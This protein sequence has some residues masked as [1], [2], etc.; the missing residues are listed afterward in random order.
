MAWQSS[1]VMCLS[2]VSR[3]NLYI[4][5]PRRAGPM[6]CPHHLLGLAFAAV[7]NSPQRPVLAA[8]D[9]VAGVPEFR[10]NSAIGWILQHPNALASADLPSDLAPELK[11]V[12]LVVDRPALVGLHINCM[13]DAAEYLLERLFSREQ[14]HVRHSDQR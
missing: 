13:V 1:G 3:P 5:K 12:T 2:G 9:G 4:P 6:T 11:V 8:C 7:R 14:A 10:R